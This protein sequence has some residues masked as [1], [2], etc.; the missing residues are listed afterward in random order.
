MLRVIG[1]Q[2]DSCPLVV[3][4]RGV[5]AIVSGL[6]CVSTGKQIVKSEL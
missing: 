5:V 6:D 1:G 2:P 3:L 4:L